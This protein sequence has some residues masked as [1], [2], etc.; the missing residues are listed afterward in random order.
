MTARRLGPSGRAQTRRGARAGGGDHLLQ[1]RR[2]AGQAGGGELAGDDGAEEGDEEERH[3]GCGGADEVAER[4]G[5]LGGGGDGEEVV[6]GDEEAGAEAAAVGL[7]LENSGGAGEALAQEVEDRCSER[8]EENQSHNVHDGCAKNSARDIGSRLDVL[9]P[10]K[11]RIICIKYRDARTDELESLS[12]QIV[13]GYSNV[14]HADIVIEEYRSSIELR[15][16]TIRR[17]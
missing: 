14:K 16:D 11:N 9:W 6:E 4:V 17:G 10:Q 12:S 13:E 7:D 2:V 3:V 1:R 15:D 5:E 8:Y